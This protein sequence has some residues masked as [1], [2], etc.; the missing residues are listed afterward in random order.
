MCV[1]MSVLCVRACPV[2]REAMEKKKKKKGR[3]GRKR[4]GS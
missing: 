3:K 1:Y 2:D 4:N